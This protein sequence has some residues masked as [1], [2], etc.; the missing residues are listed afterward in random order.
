M[1]TPS[2]IKMATKHYYASWERARK[3]L[4]YEPKSTPKLA[5]ARAILWFL[6]EGYVS[7]NEEKRTAIRRHAQ[8]AF[9]AASA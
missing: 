2:M 3:E 9:E 7:G 5:A 1:L 6:D 8:Q 4:G